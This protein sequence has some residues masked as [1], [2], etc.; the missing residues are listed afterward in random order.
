MIRP[1][2]RDD[3]SRYEITVEVDGKQYV[4][5]RTIQNWITYNW[6]TNQGASSG[7]RA[8]YGIFGQRIH[9]NQAIVIG[10]DYRKKSKPEDYTMLDDGTYVLNDPELLKY[11]FDIY[12]LDHYKDPQVIEMYDRI[13]AFNS[14]DARVKVIK[15]T[16]KKIPKIPFWPFQADGK[17]RY[18]D[19]DLKYSEY[20]YEHSKKNF[21]TRGYYISP[22]SD[23][24]IE[25]I[26]SEYPSVV[27][28]GLYR[29]EK[30]YRAGKQVAPNGG[31]I[32]NIIN[33]NS[34]CGKLGTETCHSYVAFKKDEKWIL[35][36]KKWPLKVYFDPTPRT[37]HN[38]YDEKGQMVLSDRLINIQN[39]SG[40]RN[41]YIDFDNKRH[42]GFYWGYYNTR[43]HK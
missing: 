1:D 42:Y 14:P 31:R 27:P 20:A 5:E 40:R 26:I 30:G 38:F 33:Q 29:L 23:E 7:K 19:Y 3:L 18:Y 9:D 12:L 22:I 13:E 28:Q 36:E 21:E 6:D 41:E 11:E 15:K 43:E 10:F 16:Y 35:A 24:T 37:Q 2:K 32:S 8:D 25:K 17:D 39:E 34:L 4:I